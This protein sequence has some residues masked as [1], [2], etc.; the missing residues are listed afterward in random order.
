MKIKFLNEPKNNN[1]K[2]ENI[3]NNNSLNIPKSEEKNKK[4]FS[5]II[6]GSPQTLSKEM[7]IKGL[8][9]QEKENRT[10]ISYSRNIYNKGNN[11]PFDRRNFLKL[12]FW[13]IS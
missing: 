5:P 7:I 9:E 10:L 2:S 11:G 8:D 13:N 4:Y 12:K 3:I 1:N 6:Q